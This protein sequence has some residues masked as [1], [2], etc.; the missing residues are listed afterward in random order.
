MRRLFGALALAVLGLGL[1]PAPSTTRAD[2]IH[3]YLKIDDKA[4]AWTLDE[5]KD[6]PDGMVADLTLTSQV[7]Q[8]IKWT[9]KMRI[10]VPKDAK[11]TDA[12]LLFITGGSIGNKPGR[13]D[14]ALGM[15]LAKLCSAPVAV[16]P[17]VPNQ[18]LLPDRKEDDLI[19]ETFLRYLDT[20]DA[21][22]PLLF[23]MTKSAVKAMDAIQA[24]AKEHNHAVPTKFVVTGA[25]KRGWTTWLTSSVDPRVVA[26]APMVIPTLNFKT[27][28]ANQKAV[29][30]K[31]SEQIDD[32]T[33]KGLT[34]KFDDPDGVRLWKMVDPF[35]YLDRLKQ[36]KLVINGTNDRYW[37][38]DSLNVFWDDIQGPK[39]VVYLPN[40]GHGLEKHREYA[41]NGV[42][43]LFRHAVGGQPWPKL[44]WKHD[45]TDDGH[46]RLTINASPTP[47]AAKI[48][49][50]TAKT[51]DFR[52]S[53]WEPTELKVGETMVGTKPH[54]TGLNSAV[55]GDLTFEVDGFEYHLSTLIREVKAKQA[56]E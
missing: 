39:S 22:W 21:R 42:G 30:G 16:L 20:K 15:G 33:S 38:L 27:Q 17:Q 37:T 32:Y 19:T 23:P 55:F 3:D 50:T 1:A 8:G 4:F 56:A 53:K 51:R 36:P 5:T 29:F 28:I 9:H 18:P 7:W 40:A 24:L 52:D 45:D 25:S 41:L 2:E 43:A 13:G 6:T 46:Y 48:W 26:F 14:D 49:T 31:F 35:T 10:F 34:E 44:D 11:Y 47:K 54:A 12:C